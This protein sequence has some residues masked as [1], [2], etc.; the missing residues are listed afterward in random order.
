MTR[1]LLALLPTPAMTQ[2]LSRGLIICVL[3]NSPPLPWK[4]L[5]VLLLSPCFAHTQPDSYATHPSTWVSLGQ[6]SGLWK[7]QKALEAGGGWSAYIKGLLC[8][9]RSDLAGV[10]HCVLE[11]TS[12]T[13]CSVTGSDKSCRE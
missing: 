4:I 8:A 3:Y 12:P 1:A 10:F 7:D 13:K 9:C 2:P 11:N 6:G 5:F